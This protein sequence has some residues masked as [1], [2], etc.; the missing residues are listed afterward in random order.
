MSSPKVLSGVEPTQREWL[1]VIDRGAAGM[2]PA[3]TSIDGLRAQ[4]ANPA[5]TIQN[6]APKLVTNPDLS[7]S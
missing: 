4:I 5:V 7:L 2:R 6:R 3:K 1:D